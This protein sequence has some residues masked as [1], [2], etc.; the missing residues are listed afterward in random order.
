MR[1][2]MVLLASLGAFHC[3]PSTTL[4]PISANT[5]K[6]LSLEGE[7]LV[8]QEVS[9][10]LYGIKEMK[11]V[12]ASNQ[13][14]HANLMKSLMHSG[15]KKK[16]AAEIAQNVEKKLNEAE[17]QCKESLKSSWEECR[18][19]LEDTCKN[20]YTNTCRRGFSTFTSKLHN[21]FQRLSSRF[22]PRDAQ[23]EVALNQSAENPDLEVVRIEDSFS[24]LLT[25]V[26][27]LVNR[28]AV[29]VSHFHHELDQALRR[30]FS[31]EREDKESELA[32]RPAKKALD[33]AFLE[34]EGLDDVLE[35]FFDF[36]RNVLEEFGA[37]I[38]RAFSSIHDA[39]EKTAKEE[40]KKLFP[41]FLQNRR[42][43]R[44]LRRQSSECWQLQSKCEACQGTLFTECP[45]VRELHVEL[46][47]VSQLLEAS[48]QEYEEV[49]EIVQHH[50]IDT[51][52]WL[53]NMASDFGWVTELANNNTT[54]ESIFSIATVVAQTE[55][56]S[57]TPAAVTTVEVNI[58]NSPT[59]TLTVPAGLRLQDPA[60]IQYVAQEALGAYKQMARHEDV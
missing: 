54:P 40:E 41:Q 45:N 16:G 49:L 28:S 38:T 11:E 17:Q 31:P 36:G 55:E 14:K 4:P 52:S 8:D 56:S 48:K 32:L 9:K 53:S 5:L 30:A 58:L 13:E 27:T 37:V 20:F 22:G 7:K 35:S 29:L 47:E 10:A 57:N 59:L 42:L 26:G 33:S 19:C 18:P 15:E 24:N 21:F 23:D 1:V 39:V 12:M 43:C 25:K 60:F 50:T 34:G 44:D 3:V 51:I 2:L 6:R 46:D